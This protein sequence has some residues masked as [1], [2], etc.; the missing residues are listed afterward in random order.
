MIDTKTQLLKGK[1]VAEA[2]K[3]QLSQEIKRL[4]VHDIIPSL[5]VILVGDDPASA[6]Y[7]R[8]KEKAF[9]KLGCYS[10]TFRLPSETTESELLDLLLLLNL[11]SKFHGILV[12]LPLPNHIDSQKILLNISPNKDVDGFHP[13]NLGNLL[14]GSPKFI[15]CTPN[16]V[17]QILKH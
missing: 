12:Q 13:I 7:V 8:S 17:I 9:K 4:A 1:P 5:A 14:E 16:G 6:V 10:E 15:P 2:I 3:L 11:D